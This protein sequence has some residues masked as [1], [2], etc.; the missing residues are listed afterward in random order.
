M[1][2]TFLR[3]LVKA[4]RVVAAAVVVVCFAYMTL[5]VLAQVFG[6]YLFNYS[7]S[8]TEETAKFAQIWVVFIGAGI[9]MRRGW[10]VAVDVLAGMLP[11]GP[12][13]ALSVVVAVGC[14]GFLGVVVYGSFALIELGWLFETSPVLLIPMWIIYL[15]IPLGAFYFALE[16]VLSVVERWDKPYGPRSE[17]PAEDSA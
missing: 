6:R 9:A 4:I 15:C 7:I 11:L 1:M 8:W 16:M 13:R 10:H 14:I 17:T 2:R 5:A 3:R 12:A